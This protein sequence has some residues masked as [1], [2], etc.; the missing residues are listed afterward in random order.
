MSTA[1]ATPGARHISGTRV[2]VV[3]VVVA[4]MARPMG[5]RRQGWLEAGQR[6]AAVALPAPWIVAA[7]PLLDSTLGC[8]PTPWGCSPRAAMP[9]AAWAPPSATG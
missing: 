1:R 6:G 3:V 7:I 8:F 5:V 9:A 2:G 4:V